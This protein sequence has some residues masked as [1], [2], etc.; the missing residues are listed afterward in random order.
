MTVPGSR[1]VGPRLRRL[2]V[3]ALVLLPAIGP[4]AA[5]ESLIIFSMSAFRP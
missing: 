3:A 1:T 4:P 2:A 5:A